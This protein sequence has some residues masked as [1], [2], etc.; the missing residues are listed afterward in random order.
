MA[1]LL[2]KNGRYIN[3]KSNTDESL[4]VLIENGKIVDLKKDINLN[5]STKI[6]DAKGC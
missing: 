3:P 2:I 4:D 6:V 1:K 5:G